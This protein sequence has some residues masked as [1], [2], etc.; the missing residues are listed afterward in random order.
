MLE[1]GSQ[2]VTMAKGTSGQWMG[3]VGAPN[4]LVVRDITDRRLVR[5]WNQLG[6]KSGAAVP[7]TLTWNGA[8]GFALIGVS[9]PR[10][11]S[12]GHLR[13]KVSPT[14]ELRARLADVNINVGR[15]TK[16]Q[17]R[18]F[19]SFETYALSATG[20][21]NTQNQFAYEASATLS[22]SNTNCYNATVVQASPIVQLPANLACGSITFV[23]GQ[24]TMNL[25]LSNKNGTLLFVSTMLVSG[26]PF[27]FNAV[28]ASWPVTGN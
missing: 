4:E 6:H 3:E 9:N 13:F 24:F 14:V 2:V 16:M 26:T 1:D 17:A 19:P 20:M 8:K 21:V 10:L 5:A 25:P 15:S 22:N 18:S 7:A 12:K 27:N 11:T 28:V 23:S